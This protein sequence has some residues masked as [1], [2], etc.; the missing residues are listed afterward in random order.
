M[1]SCRALELAA[2]LIRFDSVSSRSNAA[3]SD[4]VQ[5]L[6]K[7]NAFEVER[8]EYRDPNG[9]LKAN[10]VAKRNPRRGEV[11]G[12]GVAYMCHTDVVPADDW[13]LADSGPFQPKIADGKLYGR[14]SCDMKGSL[15]CALAAV[16][17]VRWDEQTSPLYFIATADEEVSMKGAR[18][19]A[20]HSKL[21]SEMVFAECVGIIGEPTELRVIHTHKGGQ[22]MKFMARGQSAHSSSR[23]GIN[24]NHAL[25]PILPRLLELYHRCETDPSL[26]NQAF[27]PPSLSWNMVIRN[28]PLANNV[29]P[30]TAEATVFIRLMPKVDHQT[31]IDAC[32]SLAE[33]HGLE[34]LCSQAVSPVYVDPNSESIRGMLKITQQPQAGSVCYA[35]DGCEFQKLKNLVVCGPGSIQ[36]AHR[37]DEWIA[38]EQLVRGTEIY[39]RA[40]RYWGC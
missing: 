10:I 19:V 21:F 5:G 20:E 13:G 35:T 18:Y 26:Q 7:A 24:A 6:L 3:I 12:A 2:E 22:T 32:Q 4:H 1:E 40:F 31:L 9:V 34:F 27:D 25:I 14:G 11:S 23:E 16:E 15:A 30:S 33:S 38:L 28:E 39:E 37:H 17:R 8:L 29:K 36:Q